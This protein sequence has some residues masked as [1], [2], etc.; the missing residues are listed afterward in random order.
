M[1]YRLVI[2][3]TFT[4]HI[5][6]LFHWIFQLVILFILFLH[7]Q[8]AHAVLQDVPLRNIRQVHAAIYRKYTSH[9]FG[10]YMTRD[11]YQRCAFGDGCKIKYDRTIGDVDWVEC[12]T[13]KRWWHLFC[14][15]MKVAPKGKYTCTHCK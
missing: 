7:S 6:D 15:K 1:Q 12:G 13:C 11:V 4:V 8:Y 9:V 10:E 2:I 5:H 14:P 3:F